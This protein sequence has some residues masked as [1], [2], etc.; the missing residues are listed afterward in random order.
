MMDMQCS[1][2]LNI[3]FISITEAGF[4]FGELPL[5]HCTL[6]RDLGIA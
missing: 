5:P 6:S 2:L 3:Y 1:V 4:S